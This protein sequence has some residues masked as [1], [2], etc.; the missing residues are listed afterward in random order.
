MI[1]YKKGWGGLDILLRVRGTSWPYGVLPG[2][3]SASM[4]LVL[5]FT[6]LQAFMEND[7]EF[8][9]NPYPFQL[10][11]YLVG[12]LLVFRTNFGYSRYWEAFD[13]VQRMGAKWLDGACMAVS[14]DA[15][16]DS[17]HPFLQPSVVSHEDY[18][19]NGQAPLTLN[20]PPGAQGCDHTEF[21]VEVMH[22]FSLL[23]ALALQHLRNDTNLENICRHHN[24]EDAVP[25]T[26]QRQMR[27]ST[28]GEEPRSSHSHQ[29]LASYE[30]RTYEK[31][32]IKVLGGVL[33]EER[34]TLLSDG[35]GNPLPTATRVTMVESWIMRRL[36]C[37]LKHESAGDMGK[38]APPILSRM[39]QVVSD[40]MLAFS[41]ASKAAEC[42]FPF[43][44][45]N[46]IRIFLTIFSL[47]VPVVINAKVMNI[48]A[49]FTINFVV[50]LTYFALA[51]ASD[52]LE[53]PYI[54]Y[55]PNELPLEALQYS[56]NA[57]LLS[58]GVTP[59]LEA[60]G[61]P[62]VISD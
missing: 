32:D 28:L 17:S 3:I 50:V 51:E 2:L 33:P 24:L 52:N 18:A 8:I 15:R 58:F 25:G 26:G 4:G 10:F 19:A 20:L 7:N 6:P 60:R 38:T 54:S 45:Q 21:F 55:D 40:G 12:F 43:P 41:Q 42:P 29:N 39:V 36:I 27:I 14:F 37:R 46:L 62:R 59:P 56:F 1:K 30:K 9:N 23:H 5:S 11:A 44:Y 13:A 31:S 34:E 57:R 49:R 61:I 47:T 35:G 53:D 22:L 48:P 16:G